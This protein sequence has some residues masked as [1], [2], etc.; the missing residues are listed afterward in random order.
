M[1][2]SKIFIGLGLMATTVAAADEVITM[3]IADNSNPQPLVGQVLGGHSDTTSYSI[4]CAE[5]VT[6]CDVD[7]AGGVTLVQAPSTYEMRAS[8]DDEAYT[9]AC[10]VGTKIATCSIKLGDEDW[11][12]TFTETASEYPVTITSGSSGVASSTPAPSSTSTSSTSTGTNEESS[13]TTPTPSSTDAEG[14]SETDSDN[15]AMAQVTGIP[16]AAGV[17]AMGMAAAVAIA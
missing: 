2:S 11:T 7:L 4:T 8:M 15:A 1:H 17:V 6:S 9:L 12:E 14:A 5:T 3:Y 10:A 16:W 13:S